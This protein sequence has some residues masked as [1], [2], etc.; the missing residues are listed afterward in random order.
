MDSQD[1]SPVVIRSTA[2]P[3]TRSSTLATSKSM[4][5]GAVQARRIENAEIGKF[6][7]LS[8]ESR[9]AIASA[10]LAKKLTQKELDALGGFPA[11]SCNTWESGRVCPTGAQIQKLHRVLGV[12]IDRT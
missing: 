5:E 4:T 1:W 3:V 9:N 12:K 2:K 10:R 7:T 6:K 8:V 11:N